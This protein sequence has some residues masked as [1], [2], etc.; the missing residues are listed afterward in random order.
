MEAEHLRK[1]AAGSSKKTIAGRR[2]TDLLWKTSRSEKG[3]DLGWKKLSFGRRRHAKREEIVGGQSG[4]ITLTGPVVE[5]KKVH[6][7]QG[8]DVREKEN[9]AEGS[10]KRLSRA[11][12]LGPDPLLKWDRTRGKGKLGCLD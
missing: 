10:R 2:G 5:K 12:D 6:T 4:F 7:V 3:R 11:K 8:A 9:A 1:L